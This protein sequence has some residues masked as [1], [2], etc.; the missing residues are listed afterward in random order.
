MNK[1]TRVKC[2]LLDKSCDSCGYRTLAEYFVNESEKAIF[3]RPEIGS[4]KALTY[5]HRPEK[6]YCK[7]YIYF[8]DVVDDIKR[9]DKMSKLI[10]EY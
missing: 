5:M 3:C 8:K 9:L 4:R 6:D 7:H 10:K 2:L 1:I